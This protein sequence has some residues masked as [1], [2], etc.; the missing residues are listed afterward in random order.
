MNP[1]EVFCPNLDCPARGRCG[2]GTVWIHS[3]TPPRYRCRVCG[4]TFGARVGT[5]FYRRHTDEATMTTVLTLLAHGCPIAAI[6]VAFGVQRQTVSAWLDAAGQQ[7]GAVH[8]HLVLVP[9]DLGQVQADELRV[10]RQGGVVWMAMAMM[11]S[12]RLWLGGVV[13]P[14]RDGALIRRLMLLVHAAALPAPILLCVDGFAAYVGAFLAITQ[15]PEALTGRRGRPR[16]RAWA[17]VVI[18]QV[19]KRREGYRVVAVTRR[20]VHG[21]EVALA[22]L[23]PQG[24]QI[25]TAYIE[26]LNATFRARLG[27][28]TRRTR[29]LARRT[30]R[31]HGGMYLLGTVYNFCTPH[32]S[33]ARAQTPTMA[34]AITDHVWTVGELLHYPVPPAPWEPLRQRGRR[35]KA[36]QRLIARWSA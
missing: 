18:G 25:H 5:P 34:A 1:H 4:K 21:T 20:L 11:V 30:E 33:L 29:G 3:R 2:E 10:R 9:R 12:T 32:A 19:V 17:G 15:M 22:R 23:L 28:L 6:V 24:Q 35:S 7:C 16:L 26:R 14:R 8:Q 13:S 31:L 27:T 36:M